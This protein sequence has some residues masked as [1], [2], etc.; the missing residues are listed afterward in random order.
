MR[1]IYNQSNSL[2]Y[3]DRLDRLEKMLPYTQKEDARLD[4]AWPLLY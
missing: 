2:W 1:S 3:N 4:A